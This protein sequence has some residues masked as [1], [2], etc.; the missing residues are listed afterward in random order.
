M[1]TDQ[2]GRY[3]IYTIKPAPYPNDNLPAHIHPVV[4]EPDVKNDYYIDDFVFDDDPLLT[5]SIREAAENRAGSGVLQT[6]NSDSLLVAERNIVLGLNIPNY[7]IKKNQPK[8]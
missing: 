5:I 6:A 7:P 3:A 4:K 8:K 2:E 1:K